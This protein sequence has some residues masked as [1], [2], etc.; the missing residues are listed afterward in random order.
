MFT[1]YLRTPIILVVALLV[2]LLLVNIMLTSILSTPAII[3]LIIMLIICLMWG[4]LASLFLLLLGIDVNSYEFGFM[5]A[6]NMTSCAYVL[7]NK[8]MPWW[9]T[10]FLSGYE[11]AK[12]FIVQALG[13]EPETYI[14]LGAACVFLF[15]VWAHRRGA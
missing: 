13:S 9:H 14:Y 10:A 7:S 2:S 4:A 11:E 5:V 3:P 1:W 8:T 15:S 12:Q 6:L